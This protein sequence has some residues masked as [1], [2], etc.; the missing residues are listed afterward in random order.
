MS[1]LRYN[2]VP[3]IVTLHLSSPLHT[4]LDM[5]MHASN[6][7]TTPRAIESGRQ[8]LGTSAGAGACLLVFRT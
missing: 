1:A 8:S 2:P 6:R 3:H 7:L 4:K 5:H